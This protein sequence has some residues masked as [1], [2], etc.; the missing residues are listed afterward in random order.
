M[1]PGGTVP[2][3]GGAAADVAAHD[4]PLPVRPHALPL[5]IYPIPLQPNA[6]GGGVLVT[7]AGGGAA[8]AHRLPRVHRELVMD[9]GGLVVVAA[10][11]DPTI[12]V[13]G[14]FAQ[15]VG[16]GGGGG[17]GAAG[18]GDKPLTPKPRHHRPLG[19]PPTAAAGDILLPNQSPLVAVGRGVLLPIAAPPV[20]V[21]TPDN[22]SNAR[23][24]S[25]NVVPPLQPQQ[26]ATPLVP[27]HGSTGTVGVGGAGS[28]VAGAVPPHTTPTFAAA[29]A[30]S[31]QQQRGSGLL[32]VHFRNRSTTP[33][34]YA[35]DMGI[36]PS[37]DGGAVLAPRTAS[38]AG[39]GGGG[40]GRYLLPAIASTGGGSG[41]VTQVS[42]A[43]PALVASS[44]GDRSPLPIH[45]SSPPALDAPLQILP[46]S[47]SGQ[48]VQP[49]PHQQQMVAGPPSAGVSHDADDGSPVSN[50]LASPPS[51][52]YPPLSLPPVMAPPP[53]PG[54][55]LP[56]ALANQLAR[57]T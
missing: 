53:P 49:Q 41:G 42:P 37:P 12:A 55:T 7:M 32:P 5:G 3:P 30:A 9:R 50:V 26:M 36:A 48:V 27:F 56:V 6:G 34:P 21:R 46:P 18:G 20:L 10:T 52:P 57:Y 44:L 16:A 31:I 39:A 47:V 35:A 33:L 38:G 2:I 13:A 15:N 23:R 11:Q 22:E 29:Q 17:G 54:A 45:P 24:L 40:G 1:I 51:L 25:P 14:T 28:I 8:G 4:I 43:T 19:A